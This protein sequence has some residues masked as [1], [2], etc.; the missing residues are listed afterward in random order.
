MKHETLSICNTP[1]TLAMA[2]LQGAKRKAKSESICEKNTDEVTRDM[3]PSTS[4]PMEH[5]NGK[6]K[7]AK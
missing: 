4:K 2:K 7:K 6:E 3:Q 5:L 1:K